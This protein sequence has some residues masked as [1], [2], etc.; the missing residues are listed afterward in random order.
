MEAS[1]VTRFV[2]NKQGYEIDWTSSNDTLVIRNL[3]NRQE[4][5]IKLVQDQLQAVDYG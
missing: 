1:H 5:T 2:D 4:Q 3:A